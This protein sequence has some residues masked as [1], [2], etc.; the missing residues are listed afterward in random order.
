[1]G[2]LRNF[3]AARLRV[4]LL[5]YCITT[6]F[7]CAPGIPRPPGAPSG[8]PPAPP[9][10]ARLCAD[11]RG[12]ALAPFAIIG[13]GSDPRSRRTADRRSRPL[14]RALRPGLADHAP[15]VPTRHGRDRVRR[16]RYDFNAGRERGR[17]RAVAVTAVAPPR[18][19][20]DHGA[21]PGPRRGRT[22]RRDIHRPHGLPAPMVARLVR[23][24]AFQNPEFYRAQAMRLSTFGKPR[25]IS[26]A[27]LHP[28]HIGLPRGCLDEMQELL[29]SHGVGTE[30]SIAVRREHPWRSASWA[31][32]AMGRPQR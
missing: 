25:I 14:P 17:R 6:L 10:S 12:Q 15:A 11:G 1:M 3:A 29:R 30:L 28:H 27:E 23:I 26:C 2:N 22:R 24:A 16:P 20:T 21:A 18:P 19:G 5:T 13:L 4:A 32:R 9:A 31:R 7:R 8:A